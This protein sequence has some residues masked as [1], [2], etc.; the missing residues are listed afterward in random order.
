MV[1]I[2]FSRGMVVWRCGVIF[3]FVAI[4]RISD[5]LF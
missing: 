4:K 5:R 3:G 2:S 1:V